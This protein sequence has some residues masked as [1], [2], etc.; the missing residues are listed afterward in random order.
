MIPDLLGAIFTAQPLCRECMEA[1]ADFNFG[2]GSLL[3]AKC[4]ADK[5]VS[6][7]ALG[8]A[9]SGDDVTG[10]AALPSKHVPVPVADP[11]SCLT[12]DRNVTALRSFAL[13]S[14][15]PKEIQVSSDG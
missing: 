13:N 7:I 4:F 14:M 12:H 5:Q 8:S 1:P 3:C 2:E 9:S 15:E 6:P 10:P 11:F